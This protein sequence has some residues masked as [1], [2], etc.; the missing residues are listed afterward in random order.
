[1]SVGHVIS[2]FDSAVWP[3]KKPDYSGISADCHSQIGAPNAAA[4]PDVLL[5]LK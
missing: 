2:P 5:F 4:I 1:M 3:G